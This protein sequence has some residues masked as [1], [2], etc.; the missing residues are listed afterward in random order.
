MARVENNQPS[1][2]DRLRNAPDMVGQSPSGRVSVI[3][4]GGNAGEP[5]TAHAMRLDQ[6]GQPTFGA[7]ARNRI[8]AQS[9]LGIAF[10]VRFPKV[11]GEL[12]P[13]R[14]IPMRQGEE[15]DLSTYPSD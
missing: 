9:I 1:M 3:F 15:I 13:R 8:D 11:E 4:T 10:G 14:V 6:D 5:V 2:H 7:S 12:I